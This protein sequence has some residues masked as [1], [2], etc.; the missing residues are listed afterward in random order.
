MR[1]FSRIEILK[2]IRYLDRT[3][4]HISSETQSSDPQ[5]KFRKSASSSPKMELLSRRSSDGRMSTLKRSRSFRASVKLMSKIRNHANMRLTAGFD[6]SSVSKDLVAKKECNLSVLEESRDGE[7]SS[8]PRKAS[9]GTNSR[10]K[11]KIKVSLSPRKISVSDLDA[12]PREITKDLKSKLSLTDRLMGKGRKDVEKPSTKDEGVKSPK[13][14]HLF[15]RRH[16]VESSQEVIR[17]NCSNKH[18]SC[19]TDTGRSNKHVFYE[20]P[21]FVDSSLD[22]SVSSFLFEVEEEEEEQR[23]EQDGENER[24]ASSKHDVLTVIVDSHEAAFNQPFYHKTSYERDKDEEEAYLEN[25]ELQ[26]AFR[27]RCETDP[28]RRP[29][30]ARSEDSHASAI[31]GN[32]RTTESFGEFDRPRIKFYCKIHETERKNATICLQNQKIHND[33]KMCPSKSC[34]IRTVDNIAN[35]W[36]NRR[37]QSFRN[38]MTTGRKRDAKETKD[39]ERL[40]QERV[41]MSTSSGSSTLDQ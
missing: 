8:N 5:M 21:T 1:T 22:S 9:E 24:A 17:K 12:D 30:K 14:I 38:K 37:G 35:F 10:V 2:R 29:C 41:F 20:N 25:E 39:Y 33:I 28:L 26:N 34:K 11:D 31:N 15:R 23:Q 4:G 32:R 36:T 19:E 27:P 16:S 3:S 18:A 13:V 6:L 40:G 7:R